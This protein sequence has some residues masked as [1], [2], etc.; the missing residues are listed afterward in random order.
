MQ[1]PERLHALDAVRAFAL[2]SGIALHGAQPFI[3]GLPW[4]T[5]ETPNGTLAG[6]WYA[7]HMFRMPLFFLLAG[8][9]GRMMLERRG[10][11]GFI[12]DRSRRI[13]L[14]LVLG[15]PIVMVVTGCAFVLGTLAM[16]GDP[17][18]LAQ[19]HPPSPGAGHQSPL[20]SINLIHL[21]FLYYLVIF[22]GGALILGSARDVIFGRSSRLQSAIDTAVKFLMRGIWGP[23]LLSLPIAAFYVHSK[24][25][26]PWGGLPAPFSIIPDAGALIAYGL[27]FGFGWLLHRQQSLIFS[28][29]NRWPLH[30]LLAVTLWIVCR[31]IAGPTPHWGPFLNHG[32][33]TVYTLAYTVG[34]W[35]A[36]LAVIG[37]AVRFLSSPSPVRRYLADSSYWLYLMHIPALAF[38]DALL[39]PLPWPASVKYLL[40]MAGAVMVLLL[41]Y[42]YLVRFTF[43]GAM[44]NG[45]R[46][47]RTAPGTL[48]PAAFG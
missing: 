9:F 5:T 36:T 16:G 40:S 18:S 6:V 11:A 21:W 26:S 15:L 25:W 1:S 44:L 4:L 2:L 28:L 48:R 30:G 10:T 47:P 35:C 20:S 12:K 43:V 22:Y 33:L 8:F 34:L 14:P 32:A 29:E 3:A 37:I 27:A 13:V 38:F 46:H 42:H 24:D 31:A 7:I 23:L 45:R 39:H 41:S 19:S 17:R